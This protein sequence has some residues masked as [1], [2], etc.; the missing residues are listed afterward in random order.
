MTTLRFLT[1][2]I[3][4]VLLA[5]SSGLLEADTVVPESSAA[6]DPAAIVP[7]ADELAQQATTE[8]EAEQML[9]TM[10]EAGSDWTS[11][12]ELTNN[13]RVLTQTQQEV[14]GSLEQGCSCRELEQDQ[15]NRIFTALDTLGAIGIT[16]HRS[17]LPKVKYAQVELVSQNFQLLILAQGTYGILVSQFGHDSSSAQSTMCYDIDTAK[18]SLADVVISS[19]VIASAVVLKG[20][21]PQ[22]FN[23]DQDAKQTF[24]ASLVSM[25]QLPTV[26]SEDQIINMRAIEYGYGSGRRLLAHKTE[27]LFDVTVAAGDM[28][29]ASSL[30]ESLA[31]Q[32]AEAVSSGS[33]ETELS[34]NS[35]AGSVLST[36][37]VDVDAS[38]L[39]IA[40]ITTLSTQAPTTAPTPVPTLAPTLAP[41]STASPTMGGS[42]SGSGFGSGSMQTMLAPT[43][44][45]TTDPRARPQ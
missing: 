9:L 20:V 22:S 19:A 41:T 29:V 14:I 25:Q 3:L 43:L 26:T 5:R 39:A 1:L 17:S 23:D 6:I 45:P 15:V 13:Q 37:T 21:D 31:T 30:A 38:T 24:A 35:L 2:S 36:A 33:M 8:M 28:S 18:A 42:G 16:V 7:E 10:I 34:A 4:L 40:T 11:C 44:P 27:I 32:L 12:E